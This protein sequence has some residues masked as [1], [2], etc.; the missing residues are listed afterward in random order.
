M[1]SDWSIN[2][3]LPSTQM[4]KT[5][6]QLASCSPSAHDNTY[7]YQTVATIDDRLAAITS[8][9]EI[10]VV[11]GASL[12]SAAVLRL[13]GAPKGLTTLSAGDHGRS[14]YCGDSAGYVSCFD[15]RTATKTGSF[16]IGQSMMARSST[17]VTDPYR[18]ASGLSTAMSF[19]RSSNRHRSHASAGGSQPLVSLWMISLLFLPLS[20]QQKLDQSQVLGSRQTFH[21]PRLLNNKLKHY[22]DLPSHEL[23]KTL[24]CVA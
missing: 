22:L 11:D 3:N 12:N 19:S 9:D 4:S 14:L 15:I 5:Y 2:V 23:L 1:P 17:L 18:R 16:S 13:H 21:E 20:S 24:G 7:I 6:V 10:L 8:R